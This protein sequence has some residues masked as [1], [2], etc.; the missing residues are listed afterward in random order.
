MRYRTM[1]FDNGEDRVS[2]LGF[3]CMRFPKTEDGR[4]D[5]A[6]AAK[7]LD[8]AIKAGVNYIDTAYPYH[9]GASEPFVGRVLSGYPRAQFFLA[10]QLPVW[11][12][13]SAPAGPECVEEPLHSLQVQ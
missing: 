12:A 9:D 2:F 3:G 5:E 8:T 6:Q 13:D 1:R 10:T 4:I 11:K 7:M